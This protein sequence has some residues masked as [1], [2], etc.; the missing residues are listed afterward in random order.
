M[1][2]SAV[3]VEDDHDVDDDDVIITIIISAV[4]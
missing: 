1:I 4:L 2:A 3:D